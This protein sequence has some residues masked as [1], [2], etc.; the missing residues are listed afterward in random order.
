MFNMPLI[1]LLLHEVT[2]VEQGFVLRA[3]IRDYL[4]QLIPEVRLVDFSPGQNVVVHQGIKVFVDTQAGNFN[5]I[6]HDS[7]L[8]GK[9]LFAGQ[10]GA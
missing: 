6:G 9:D 1:D 8:S 3:E 7:R 5:S 2:F 4:S 10:I